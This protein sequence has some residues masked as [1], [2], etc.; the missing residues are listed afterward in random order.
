MAINE[1][2][3]RCPFCGQEAMIMEEIDGEQT[4]YQVVCVGCL[5]GTCYCSTK[6]EAIKRWNWRADA[7]GCVG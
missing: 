4:L 5:S 7:I 2:L 6:D 1:N 3:K